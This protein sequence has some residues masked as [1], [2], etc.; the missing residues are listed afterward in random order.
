M[1]I[2]DTAG[3]SML[4]DLMYKDPQ[5]G[6]LK[7]SDH[8]LKGR[9]TTYV[10]VPYGEWAIQICSMNGADVLVHE[11]GKRLLVTSVPN[12]TQHIA[13]DSEGRA[14]TFAAEDS[15]LK[16]EIV[17]DVQ[18]HA[19]NELAAEETTQTDGEACYAPFVVP[20]G[21]G[22]VYVVVRFAKEN[23][24]FG[25]PPQEEFEIAFQMLEQTKEAPGH[26]ANNFRL[27]E[28]APE[29]PNPA[30]PFSR[31]PAKEPVNK[32]HFHCVFSGCKH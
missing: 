24:P 31:E 25:E 11:N 18:V 2:T 32:P 20:D 19:G 21:H 8:K 14:F 1:K 28:R 26:F 29:L 16:G 10:A 13:A 15:K 4:V 12:M 7:A 17:T 3:R 22:M 6:W 9:G 30:D 23:N 27:V 5:L